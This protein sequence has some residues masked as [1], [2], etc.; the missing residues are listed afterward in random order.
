MTLSD[1]ITNVTDTGEEA[2]QRSMMGGGPGMTPNDGEMPDGD[3]LPNSDSLPNNGE[4][5][6]KDATSND[7][8]PQ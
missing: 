1:T 3:E 6:D 7:G 4:M 8:S 2:T 5:Q